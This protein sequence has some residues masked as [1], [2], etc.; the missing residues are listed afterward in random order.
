MTLKVVAISDTHDQM[1]KI[2]VPDADILIHNGDFSNSGS[3]TNHYEFIKQYASLPHK[4]KLLT[5][6]NHDGWSYKNPEL[7]KELCEDYLIHF[8]VD[9]EIVIEGKRIYMSPYS[10]TFGTWYWMKDRGEPIAKVWN[11]IPTGLDILC[12][13]G[14]AYGILDV[15]VYSNTYCGCE[16]LLKAIEEKKPKYHLFGHIHKW[17]GQ[18]RK[19]ESTTFYNTSVCDERYEPTNKIVE[20][21]I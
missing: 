16:E 18:V 15:S 3:R 17:G 8:L 10:P 13:H 19:N 7:F 11:K 21:E 9:E 20:F 4:Y 12:T 1:H 5:A 6:G 14:P 2:K